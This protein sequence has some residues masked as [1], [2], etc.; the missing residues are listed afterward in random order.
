MEQFETLPQPAL[1]V[2]RP[3]EC[4]GA[5]YTEAA[6]QYYALNSGAEVHSGDLLEYWRIARRH[7]TSLFLFA[8][9]GMLLGILAG[10]PQKAIYKVS[11]SIEVLNLNEDFM[12]MKQTNPTTSS[13]ESYDTSEEQTQVKLLQSD[14]LLERVVL[15]LDPSYPKHSYT[16]PVVSGWRKL[17]NSPEPVRL[18]ERQALLNRMTDTLKVKSVSRTR[19]IEVTLK[20]TDPK[21]AVAFANALANEFIEQNIEARWKT[22]QRVGDWLSRELNDE[23]ANLL[24]SEDALQKYARESG[25]IFTD[26]NTNVATEKLQQ[27]QQQL[28]AMTGDRIGKQSR[29]ELAQHSPPDSLPDV[30]NDDNLRESA[31]K[32]NDLRRQIADLSAIFTPDYSKVKRLEAELNALNVAFQTDRTNV[33]DRIKNEYQEALRKEQL[34]ASDYDRQTQEVTGQ[35]EKAIQYNT[36]KREVDS[37]RQLYDRMLQQTKQSSIAAA[38]HASNLRI[39]DPAELP[40][41]PI[42]PNFKILS[43]AGFTS[44]LFLG[45]AVIMVRERA[46]R[47]LQQPGDVQLWTKLPELGTIPNASVDGKRRRSKHSRSA[48]ARRKEN[49]FYADK[50]PSV[51]L[52]T[53]NSKPSLMAEAFRSTLT[54]ILFVGENGSRPTVLVAT[55]ANASDGKTTVV[56]NLGIAIAEARRSVLLLDADLRRPRV[57][58]LFGLSNEHGLSDLLGDQVLSD[59]RISALIQKTEI[60]GLDIIASGPSTHAAAN[61]LYSPNL[62]ELVARL[63]KRYDMVLIDT[64]PMLHMTDARVIGRLADAV[65]LVARAEQTTRDAIVA[66]SQR[67]SED[68]IRVLG[69]I[70]NDWDPNRSLAGPYGYYKTGYY[71]AEKSGSA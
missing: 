6:P 62:A 29:Y 61:L 64:P 49:S 20:S 9:C 67:L 69:T 66:A 44:G 23:R 51:E 4:V 7:K 32:I 50:G 8:I 24:R 65:V 39:V 47:S 70:L 30:V 43:F 34:L 40:D 55:S 15:I 36:L 13:D 22:T 54:S 1:I 48:E 27:L 17:L 46:D 56:T 28:T 12:N 59:A 19:V 18:T 31:A 3:P 38:L 58:E 2:K 33:I 41:Q 68:G 25:L 35:D 42:W 63:K 52:I 11:T 37:H 21:L 26:D 10:L 53:W 60:P 57:H 16:L 14:S 71:Y 45:I 5:A